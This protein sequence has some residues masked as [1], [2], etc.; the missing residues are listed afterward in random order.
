MLGLSDLKPA[1]AEPSPRYASPSADFVAADGI[2][3][4]GIQSCAMEEPSPLFCP[5]N[6]RACR[7]HE[8]EPSKGGKPDIE[9]RYSLTPSKGA[10]S[11]R[12][13]AS[14]AQFSNS[15][16]LEPVRACRYAPDT[17][18]SRVQLTIEHTQFAL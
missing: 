1:V 11:W 16:K 5:V 6:T 3:A 18:P 13:L 4:R 15:V 10:V 9:F 7:S 12:L 8:E 2:A 17:R 14:N